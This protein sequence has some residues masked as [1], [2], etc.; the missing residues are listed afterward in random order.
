MKRSRYLALVLGWDANKPHKKQAFF[1][2]QVWV[3]LWPSGDS[4]TP[5]WSVWRARATSGGN[6][7][8]SLKSGV[9]MQHDSTLAGRRFQKVPNS[10]IYNTSHNWMLSGGRV[11]MVRRCSCICGCVYVCRYAYGGQRTPSGVIS[12]VLLV[13]ETDPLFGL[14]LAKQPYWLTSE[15]PRGQSLPHKGGFTH[16]HHH[17]LFTFIWVLGVQLRSSCFQSEYYL[18]QA[19]SGLQ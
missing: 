1:S 15:P 7:T 8:S 4:L 9:G 16:R 12:Q 3:K 11:C 13:S 10:T 17:A 14:E 19:L 18:P 2:Y 5:L 6:L